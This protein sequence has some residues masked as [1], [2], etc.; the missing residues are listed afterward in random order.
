MP[1]HLGVWPSSHW[2]SE[3]CWGCPHNPPYH[4]AEPHPYI[5]ALTC[6][7]SW[8]RI[9]GRSPRPPEHCWELTPSPKENVI[10]PNVYKG[11][12]EGTCGNHWF[13]CWTQLLF[14]L[15]S[16]L[17]TCWSDFLLRPRCTLWPTRWH[18]HTLT[19]CKIQKGIQSLPYSAL[20]RLPFNGNDNSV[21]LNV[22]NSKVVFGVSSK[23]QSGSF[24][25]SIYSSGST[26]K[27][28]MGLE[29]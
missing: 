14:K 7:P 5:L 9:A 17:Q 24:A 13:L 20:N 22:F 3:H 23:L 12:L 11:T 25:Q 21:S 19:S 16:G 26:T 28:V 29:R 6:Q 15:L 4:E 8:L 1:V 27:S 2:V 18:L 10:W